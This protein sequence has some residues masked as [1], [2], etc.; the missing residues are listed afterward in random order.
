MQTNY[1]SN[2]LERLYDWAGKWQWEFNVGECRILGV[3]STN[4]PHKYCLEDRP[5][6]SVMCD[7]DLKVAARGLN[8]LKKKAKR[9]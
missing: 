6:S 1:I 7:N 8:A 9:T 3:G 5:L 2:E 4:Y